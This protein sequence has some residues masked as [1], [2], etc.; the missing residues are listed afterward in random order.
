[1]EDKTYR[2]QYWR[3]KIAWFVRGALCLVLSGLIFSLSYFPLQFVDSTSDDSYLVTLEIVGCAI[4]MVV[5]FGAAVSAL[6]YGLFLILDS[7]RY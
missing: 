7:A 1:M 4:G 3:T 2:R 6:A 5:L